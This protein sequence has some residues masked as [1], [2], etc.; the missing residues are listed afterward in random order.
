MTLDYK[1]TDMPTGDQATPLPAAGP[2][3]ANLSFI[4]HGSQYRR[5][6]TDST[7]DLSKLKPAPDRPRLFMSKSG[8][9]V[10]VFPNGE[11]VEGK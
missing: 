2:S 9:V 6:Q 8:K 3:A 1:Q 5:C 4:K 10:I 7:M 11:I